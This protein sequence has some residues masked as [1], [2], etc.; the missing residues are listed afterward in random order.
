MSEEKELKE[1]VLPD[2]YPTYPG[3]CYVADGKVVISDIKGTVQR[4]KLY[5]KANEIRNCDI[6]GRELY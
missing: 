3:Y 6:V 2:D 4:L 5:L 1:R